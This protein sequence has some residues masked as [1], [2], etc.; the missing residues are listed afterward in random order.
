MSLFTILRK[1]KKYSALIFG[2]SAGHSKPYTFTDLSGTKRLMLL[3]THF[4]RRNMDAPFSMERLLD[5]AIGTVNTL[6]LPNLGA[7]E[8]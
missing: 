1:D 7:T 5:T 2:R 3:E 4:F 6:P 8:E